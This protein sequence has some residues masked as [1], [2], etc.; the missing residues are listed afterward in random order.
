MP[1]R[2]TLRGDRTNPAG[3]TAIDRRTLLKLA[4][5]AGMALAAVAVPGAEGALAGLQDTGTPPAMPMATP[6]LGPQADGSALWK[7]AVGGMDMEN[8]IEYHGFFP[9]EITIN[10]G[11]SIWFAWEMPMF[12]T[13]TFPGPEAVPAILVPD[14]EMTGP[15]TPGALPK[16]IINPV[17]VTG[18]G[19]NAVDGSQLVSTAVDVFSD[20]TAPWVFTFPTAGSYDYFCVPHASVMQGRVIV[21]EAGAAYPADQAAYDQMAADAIAALQA[22]GMAQIEQFS[23][24]AQSEKE[25]GGT[26]WEV[27]AGAGGDS[28]TRVQRFLPDEI[29]IAVGDSIKYINQSPGE[30]HTVSFLGEGEEA[31]ID[32][33]EESF[34]DGTPKLVQSMETFLPSGGNTWSG[35]GFLNSGFTG[36]PE[37]GLPMEFEVLFDTAG[38]YIVYCILHGTPDGERMAGRVIVQ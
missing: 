14:P 16:L 2:D 26:L 28:Q 10:A 17:V 33:I 18:A 21:Q 24:P 37:L 35:T 20:P 29:T 1:N 11:D 38:E 25:G 3:P 15:A 6:A 9:G 19:G 31:P 23:T 5:G 12:H 7:V 4:S 8:A 32:T 30:P 13:V 34:A 36:I 22:E 27:A